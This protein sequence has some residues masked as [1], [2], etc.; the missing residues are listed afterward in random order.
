[1]S[2][3]FDRAESCR[4]APQTTEGPFYFDVDRIRSD[5]REDRE[6]TEL[7]LGVRV[8]AADSCTPIENAVVDVWHCDALGSY[9]GFEEARGETY[10]RGAQVTNSDG[11][12]Q[13][14]TVYPG[15]YP[16][17]TPH[18]HAKV[19]LDRTTVLTTQLYFTDDRTEIVYESEPY[20]SQP[21]RTDTNESDPLFDPSLTLTLAQQRGPRVLGAIT[22]DV[23]RA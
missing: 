6:G 1:M 3:L 12:A 4:L 15:W 13:F 22:I 14:K 9:S 2:D 8:R 23:E 10:C 18:V 21:D 5:I 19:H 16:G 7:R 17:R 11:I 20:A